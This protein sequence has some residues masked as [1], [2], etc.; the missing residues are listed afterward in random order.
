MNTQVYEEMRHVKETY[1]YMDVSSGAMQKGHNALLSIFKNGENAKDRQ[2]INDASK[3]ILNAY[4]PNMW[5]RS[6]KTIYGGAFWECIV[7]VQKIGK[8][9]IYFTQYDYFWKYEGLTLTMR[10]ISKRE[11][12]V[13]IKN[14]LFAYFTKSLS[15]ISILDARPSYT[16]AK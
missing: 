12:S 6:E 16:L 11:G 14:L 7:F 15:D 13:L 10:E 5:W 2:T 3:K 9:R 4:K 1:P 8:N